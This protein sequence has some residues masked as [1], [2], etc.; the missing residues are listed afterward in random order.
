LL[1]KVRVYE[2]LPPDWGV[3]E[4]KPASQQEGVVRANDS[5]EISDEIQR[6]LTS[7]LLSQ[8]TR[9]GTTADRESLVDKP[10]FRLAYDAAPGSGI[11][12]SEPVSQQD[13]VVRAVDNVHEERIQRGLTTSLLRQ[14]SNV[15]KDEPRP[16][17]GPMKKPP[18]YEQ[19]PGSGVFENEPTRIEGVIRESDATDESDQIRHG[20]TRSLLRQWQKQGSQ[21]AA[22]AGSVRRVI[23]VAEGEGAVSENEPAERRSDVIRCDDDSV[24]DEQLAMLRGMARTL[25]GEWK[26]KGV[27]SEPA[28]S[29]QQAARIVVAEDEGSVSENQPTAR[30][31]DVVHADDDSAENDEIRRGTTRSLLDQWQ[32]IGSG[33]EAG[34]SPRGRR[35]VIV[36][37]E[38]DGRVAESEPAAQRTDVV[39]CDEF[40]E[41]RDDVAA[42]FTRSL[43]GQWKNRG[44]EEQ[45]GGSGRRAPVVVNDAEGT[46]A[47]SQPTS[48]RDDVARENDDGFAD[49]EQIERGSTRT[50]R[51]QWQNRAS[52]EFRADRRP[53]V[54]AEAEGTVSENEP[55]P[56]PDVTREADGEPETEQVRAG[57]TRSLLSQWSA[58][59]TEEFRAERRP[60][61]V[62]EAEE[63][64]SEN[65]PVK[66]TD[67]VHADD[68]VDTTSV[69]RGTTRS[70]LSQWSSKGSEEFRADRSP[71]VVAE[72]EGR[73]SESE[74][75]ARPEGVVRSGDDTDGDV[76]MKGFT[77]SLLTQWKNKPHEEV[78][79]EKK[80]IVIQ[81]DE[82]TIAEST[83]TV[84]EDVVRCD[85]VET[86]DDKVQKGFTKNLKQQWMT[87]GSEKFKIEKQPINVAEGEGTVSENEPIKRSG[88]IHSDD[89]EPE[90]TVQSGIT[91]NLR[92][93][94]M[95]KSSEEFRKEKKVIV[96]AEDEGSVAE[97]APVKRSDVVHADDV[98][99]N[100]QVQRGITKNLKAQWMTKGSEKFKIERQPINIA[101]GEGTV[102]ENEPIK[103]SD[104]IRSDDLEPEETVQSGITKNLRAQWM[105]KGS[106]EFRKENKVIVIAEDEGSVAE[107]EPVRRSDIIHAY[108]IVENDQVQRGITKNL[109]AQWMTKGSEKFKIERQP[110]NIAEGDGTVA[111]N[112][113]IKRSDVIHSDDLEPEETVL[114]GITKNL[115]A[116]WMTK[117]SE[118]F[119][120]E[121][122]V[123]VIAED[124]GSVA[125]NEPVRRSDII[126]ADDLLD[127]DQ[128]Q[129]GITKNL[130]AQWMSKGSEKFT[131]D[132]EPINV[133]EAEGTVSE[134][135][136]IRRSDVVHCDDV[137]DSEQLQKGIT[138]NLRA[139][140]MTKGSEEFQAKRSPIV[141]AED[142]GTVSENDPVRR[143]DVVHSD[144]FETT[145][146]QVQ[147]GFAKTLRT[148]WLAKGS[149]QYQKEKK[150]IVVAEGEGTVAENEPITRSDVVHGDAVDDTDQ[151][152]RGIA[153]NLRQQ[154]LSKGS[155]QFRVDRAPI[156]LAEGEGT[157]AENEPI[158]RSGVI[159][160]DDDPDDEQVLQ[161][162]MTS[163][164]RAQWMSK[165]CE[166][167]RKERRP[168]VV[169]EGEGRVAENEPVRRSDVIRCDDDESAGDCV[170]R[171]TTRSLLSQWQCRGA[172]D[173]PAAA[174]RPAMINV[175][176]DEGRVVENEPV[177]RS[178]VVR[179]D[180]DGCPEQDRVQRGLTRSLMTQWSAKGAEEF[181]AERKPIVLAEAE[182][183]VAES[184]PV[185]RQ[186]VV[187]CDDVDSR[188]D[189]VATGTTRNLLSEWAVKGSREFVAERKPIVLAEAE[190]GVS[191]NEP[192]AQRDDVVRSAAMTTDGETIRQ[193]TTGNLLTQWNTLASDK[194]PQQQQQQQRRAIV[195]EDKLP[196]S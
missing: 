37:D 79:V 13:G 130:K 81:E 170:E 15:G 151:V 27:V 45:Q 182:G 67:V 70:L 98:V 127:N 144:D 179:C 116:Q 14:W 23:T 97:N 148:Q 178:D 168:I 16:R 164:L 3:Y 155:E 84:R 149:E 125:E 108:D 105:T 59:G 143:S 110:I 49:T 121:K 154:W 124:E 9:I 56:R 139:Q 114:S 193:G 73:V 44:S 10:A 40:V 135:D 128:V 160:C 186:D 63:C 82:G 66:R 163:S 109:K 174:E 25:L 190:G 118:E 91:K 1:L 102:A 76:L 104:V 48:H 146:Q 106:E 18:T 72:D 11:F 57:T 177:R 94:W 180:E 161:R 51:S 107:S 187:H 17:N 196:T 147:K 157:V 159:R 142:E 140:W 60:I 12:E 71:I 113:P 145:S 133:A 101:E 75:A 122:K 181:R 78:R 173:R 120:K 92:A 39:R 119:R 153:K 77:K 195:I 176:E 55:A 129:R 99:E 156:V 171:G 34:S 169:A 165:G 192:A 43:V 191:E 111:E 89:L 5:V 132:K 150:A 184:E 189:A 126:H 29:R 194:P 64:V 166:E 2:S 175:A 65:E 69:E 68:V 152:Q 42:G 112:E 93:Q 141:V 41:D 21:Q 137:E 162:G 24:D 52:Q 47:E 87:K 4:S 88:V 131:I 61:V 85:D 20:M 90:E 8:W 19:V 6:G 123:I 32:H 86:A 80:R 46:V 115:R 74:P 103:R 50:L 117:G 138:K 53:I 95:T 38:G 36:L 33:G 26:N 185:R 30:R 96:I 172:D 22:G 28:S 83:P 54:L 31:S 188:G 7:S 183:R 134:N 35:A 62:A 58:K 136:P 167:Y 158:R 100:E